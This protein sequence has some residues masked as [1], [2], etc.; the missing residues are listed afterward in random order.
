[1]SWIDDLLHA[2]ARKGYHEVKI[3]GRGHGNMQKRGDTPP[4]LINVT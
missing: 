4:S 2:I 3:T 1:M